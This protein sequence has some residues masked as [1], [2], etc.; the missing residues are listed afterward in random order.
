MADL[1]K[2]VGSRGH[3]QNKCLKFLVAEMNDLNVKETF[4]YFLFYKKIL[5]KI[6]KLTLSDILLSSF[7]QLSSLISK[8]TKMRKADRRRRINK[9]CH[10]LGAVKKVD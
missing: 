6:I 2:L 7:C 5:K 9:H 8:K 10:C 4:S 1:H 3:Y